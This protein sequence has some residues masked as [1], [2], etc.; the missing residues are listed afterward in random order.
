MAEILHYEWT[1]EP[2]TIPFGDNACVKIQAHANLSE[3]TQA[4]RD[5]LFAY[6]DGQKAKPKRG[7]PA[8]KAD[9][10]KGDAGKA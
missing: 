2:K 8:K 5:D 10:A 3:M 1:P 6:I 9:A 7:R 4:E